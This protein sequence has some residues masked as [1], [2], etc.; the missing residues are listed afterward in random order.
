[1]QEQKKPS[2]RYIPQINWRHTLLL[3]VVFGSLA[4][5]L[6]IQPIAQ[7]QAYHHFADQLAI[8]GIPNFFD[9]ISNIPFLLVGIAGLSFCRGSRLTGYR[10]AWVT[11]FA[12]VAIISAGS[13]WY[14]LNPN[15]DTLVWDRLPMTIGLMG[16]LVALLAEYV[17]ARLGGF[18]LVPAILTGLSSVLYWQ[19]YDDLRFYVWIQFMPLLVIPVL[20]ALFRPE[21]SRQNLLL[22]ALSFY[23]LAKFLE[24][25][26]REVYVFTRGIF[27]GHTLKHLAAALGCY[28]VLLMLRVREPI[29]TSAN[30]RRTSHE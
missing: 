12:G 17:H 3:M 22:V 4:F 8:L 23:I 26:D 29:D 28:T 18:L 5:M 24:G 13:A 25:Y 6:A 19:W 7:D 15:N 11:F 16:L 21:Y 2:P 14:H 9:V 27:S 30:H 10:P 20:M 1:M